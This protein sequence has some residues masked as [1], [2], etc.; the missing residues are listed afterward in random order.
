MTQMSFDFENARPVLQTQDSND[1]HLLPVS[2]EQL[3]FARKIASSRRK[4][5]PD[6]ALRDRRKLS[7]WIDANKGATPASGRFS[8]YPSSKQVAFAERI[9]R[10]KRRSVPDECFRDKL[11]MSRWIDS[12]R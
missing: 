5:L 2:E 8:A 11:L 1:Y 9:A 7:E 10:V 6:A 4:T 3:R 12:N